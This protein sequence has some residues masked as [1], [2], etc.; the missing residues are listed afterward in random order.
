MPLCYTAVSFRNRDNT[1]T[2]SN[3]WHNRRK[4][5]PWDVMYR[6]IVCALCGSAWL[7]QQ[8]LIPTATVVRTYHHRSKFNMPCWKDEHQCDRAR[9]F[10]NPQQTALL[11]IPFP[12]LLFPK[13]IFIYCVISKLR[14]I[15][16]VHNKSVHKLLFGENGI[17]HDYGESAN[18][19]KN[20]YAT[21]SSSYTCIA[22]ICQ[23]LSD[24]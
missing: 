14:Y 19:D 7:I 8:G 11:H 12:L 13:I 20:I 22:G 17:T 6:C 18:R 24:S 15:K 21:R 10:R 1:T 3:S 5:R 9:H 2:L 4:K 23:I 16:R